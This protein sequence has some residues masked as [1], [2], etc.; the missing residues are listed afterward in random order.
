VGIKYKPVVI[1]GVKYNIALSVGT[2]P[3]EQN[4]FLRIFESLGNVQ[5]Q[6]N[7]DGNYLTRLSFIGSD[8]G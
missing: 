6:L 8:S 2:N 7:F 3:F 5:I 1:A 4:R